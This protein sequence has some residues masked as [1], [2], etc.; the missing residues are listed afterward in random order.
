MS[1]RSDSSRSFNIIDGVTERVDVNVNDDFDDEL[2]LKRG[3]AKSKTK[4][5]VLSGRRVEGSLI[6]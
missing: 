1:S 3:G 5:A 6:V 4:M 2:H